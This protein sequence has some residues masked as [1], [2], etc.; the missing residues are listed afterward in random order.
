MNRLFAC[1]TGFR[2]F[3]VLMSYMSIMVIFRLFDLVN[4][5]EFASNLQLAVVAYCGANLGE[6]FV[7]AAKQWVK[8]KAEEFKTK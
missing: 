5:A 4:G 6:H 3:I 2:K 7:D 1:L 8:A